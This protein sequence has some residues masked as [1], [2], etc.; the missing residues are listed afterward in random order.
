MDLILIRHGTTRG[1]LERRFIG[2]TDD[3]LSPEGIALAEEAARYLP[4]V[5]RV[6]CSPLQRC[7]ETAGLLWPEAEKTVI[8]EL[9]END[10]GAFENKNHEDLKDDP[11]YQQW[12][13]SGDYDRIPVGEKPREAMERTARGL[14][15]L[16]ADAKDHSCEL[17]GVVAHG[18][19]LMNLLWQFGRPARPTYHDWLCKN[20]NGYR[21]AV[22]EDPLTLE[23]VSVLDQVGGGTLCGTT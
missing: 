20:C 10:F 8:A 3:P 6:Y 16:L 9:R 13:A 15:K 7:R 11:T 22:R 2:V 18:G 1:N 21:V 17:A 4:A 12:V 5:D 14:M 19:T 23:V